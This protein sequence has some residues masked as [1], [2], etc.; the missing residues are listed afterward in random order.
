MELNEASK[1]ERKREATRLQNIGRQL[2]L[3]NAAQLSEMPLSNELA[4]AI[5]DYHRFSSN[6]SRRR[7][8]QLIGK[9]MRAIDTGTLEAAL[10]LIEGRSAQARFQLRKFEVWRDR[11]IIEPAAL[12]EY[13]SEHVDT[14]RQALRHHIQRARAAKD[15]DQQ[16]L[17]ARAL[18]QFLRN[19]AQRPG[20][21][22]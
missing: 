13:L 16:R 9:H 21:S 1:S 3:L 22:D 7:Q 15:A 14:D 11:L 20:Q 8:L 10:E 12:T 4:K 6:E 2:T 5:A 19:A 17:A 18:F